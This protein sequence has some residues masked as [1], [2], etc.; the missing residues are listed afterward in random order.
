MKKLRE[1]LRE[2]KN[3]WPIR[4]LALLLAFFLWFYLYNR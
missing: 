1:L 4:L 3:D 2:L